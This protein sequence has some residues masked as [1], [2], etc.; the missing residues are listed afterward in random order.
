METVYLDMSVY[1]KQTK[2]SSELILFALGFKN[3]GFGEK[4]CLPQGPTLFYFPQE[5]FVQ[6]NSASSA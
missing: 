4:D 3:E 5:T 6:S 1:I 2:G